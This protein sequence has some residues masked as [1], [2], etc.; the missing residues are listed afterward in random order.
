[1]YC[2]ESFRRK[3]EIIRIE[4]ISCAVFQGYDFAVEFGDKVCISKYNASLLITKKTT[5][6][7]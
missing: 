3:L 4:G 2:H 7:F 6:I 5:F 1:M